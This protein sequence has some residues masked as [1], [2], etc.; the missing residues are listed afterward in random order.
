M[1]QYDVIVIGGGI[2]GAFAARELRRYDLSAALL[3]AAEDLCTGITRANSAIVYAGYDNKPGSRKASMTVRGNAG[4]E[5]VC[6]ELEVPFRRCGSLL[7][8]CSRETDQIL[9]KKLIQGLENGVPGLWLFDRDETLYV[10]PAL[11]EQVTMSLYVPSTGVVD[12][13]ALTFAAWE[14]ASHN[15]CETF[16][17]TKV[18]GLERTK[19]GYGVKTNRE[20]FHCRAIVNCAGL[21]ADKVQELL[22]PPTIRLFW[23]AADYLVLDEK[24]QKPSRVIFHQD[25]VCGKGITAIPTADGKLLL[26]GCRRPMTELWATT[27]EGLE[28]LHGDAKR[29]LPE[30]DLSR[31]IRSFGAVR[32]NPHRVAEQNGRWV[33]D[34]K[35]LG[36]F[37]I[38]HPE[39][40]FFSLIGVKTPGLTCARELGAYVAKVLSEELQA[41]VNRSF[42]PH[43]RLKDCKGGRIL[44]QCGKITEGEVRDA[45][46][47]GAK[48]LDGVKRRIGTGLGQCQGSRCNYA[49]EQLLEERYGKV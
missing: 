38:Q 34:G 1:K 3:E 27:T 17:D 30:L 39:I 4:M 8:S 47:R 19:T 23:D 13:W 29:L 2:L 24:A 12:P 25:E 6:E 49:I 18:L 28:R 35:S 41:E 16:F 44:C 43:R 37:C 15:G 5:G 46:A 42:D 48:T 31:V 36:D 22:F 21:C 32:P 33:P 40:G 14:N 9:E 45:V 10:E 11:T 7:V 26:S 20:E